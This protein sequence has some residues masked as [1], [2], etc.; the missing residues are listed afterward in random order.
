MNLNAHKAYNHHPLTT[1]LRSCYILWHQGVPPCQSQSKIV[2][3]SLSTMGQYACTLESM[4]SYHYPPRT[5]DKTTPDSMYIYFQLERWTMF[6]IVRNCGCFLYIWVKNY[7]FVQF[8]TFNQHAWLVWMVLKQQAA[9]K[10]SLMEYYTAWMWNLSA[11]SLYVAS[12]LYHW[13]ISLR[14]GSMN[15]WA[16]YRIALSCY[17][18]TCCIMQSMLCVMCVNA[19]Y[20]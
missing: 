18:H 4:V 10:L 3:Q 9:S 13:M 17:V 8:Y 20:A 2:T 7:T 12:C 1:V 16:I 6:P 15:F 19:A 14:F 11:T 5:E